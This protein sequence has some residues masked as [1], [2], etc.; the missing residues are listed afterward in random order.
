MIMGEER[1]G[2]ASKTQTNAIASHEALRH[3]RFKL[4]LSGKS[5]QE[6]NKAVYNAS[7]ENDKGGN[8]SREQIVEDTY[9]S[10]F[11]LLLVWVPLSLVVFL[12]LLDIS[13]V[14]TVNL[15]T[16]ISIHWH[17]RLI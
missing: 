3:E 16:E 6:G 2:E 5:S 9:V 4:S 12:M 17:P 13:I 14:A 8:T 15:P 10:G 7:P 11:R 1:L